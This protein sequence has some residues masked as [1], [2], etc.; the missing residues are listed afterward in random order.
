MSYF[1]L[2]PS[3]SLQLQDNVG[4]TETPVAPFAGLKLPGFAGGLFV[5][6]ATDGVGHPVSRNNIDT[7]RKTDKTLR[8]KPFFICPSPFFKLNSCK[9]NLYLKDLDKPD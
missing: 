3:G 9:K 5:D 2:S 1:K 8:K 7:T 4:V 6:G